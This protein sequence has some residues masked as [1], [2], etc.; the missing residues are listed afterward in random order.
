MS[1]RIFFAKRKW[2]SYL[3]RAKWSSIRLEVIL[4]LKDVPSASCDGKPM[5]PTFTLLV[6]LFSLG[7]PGEAEGTGYLY[8]TGFEVK[9]ELR[10]P[11]RPY[12]AQPGDIC[13]R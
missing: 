4:E 5:V 1:D 8:Q 7:I 2:L 13:P 11:S 9:G 10:E 12:H 6:W 3:L